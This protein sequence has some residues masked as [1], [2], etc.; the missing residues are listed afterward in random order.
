MRSLKE[1]CGDKIT[2]W[3]F[4]EARRPGSVIVE[5]F[6]RYYPLLKK[7]SPKLVDRDNLNSALVA[8]DSEEVDLAPK[9]EDEGD[10][11]VHRSR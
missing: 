6:P 11:E 9:N 3:P 10:D 5:I 8:F 1:R 2:I 7:K 4:E